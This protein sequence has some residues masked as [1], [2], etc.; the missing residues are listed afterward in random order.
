MTASVLGAR[1]QAPLARLGDVCRVFNGSTPS[2]TNARFWNGDIVWVTP[3]DLGKL[4]SNRIAD[5]ARRITREGLES[6]NTTLVPPGAVVLSSRAPIGYVAIADVPLCTNQGCKTLVP[7]DQLDSE[8]LYYTLLANIANLRQ[9]GSGATFAEISKSQVENFRIPVPPLAEQRRI[10]AQLT[11]TMAVI[12][13]ARAAAR[14]RL[15]AAEALPA[16]AVTEMF[17]RP[18][19][20][21]YTRRRVDELCELLPSKSITNRGDAVVQVI[22]T[23]CL[24]ERGFLSVGIKSARMRSGDVNA[25]TVRRGEILVARSNTPDL[26]GRAT[27]F[28]GVPAGVVASDLTIRLWCREIKDGVTPEYLSAYM[29]FLFLSG[30]WRNRARGASGS[31]KKITR[32]LLS[33]ERI[34]VPP[35]AEQARIATSLAE[36][37]RATEFLIANLREQ[38][39]AL[40]ALP[41]ALL[42]RVFNGACDGEARAEAQR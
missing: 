28:P 42:C 1:V 13:R 9:L 5:S 23:A 11:A 18:E 12:D 7:G 40:D 39:A 33:A 31:M 36:R 41:A 21:A 22:T 2:S 10:A 25:C 38:V 20:G 16:A 30:Y 24:S 8:F 14:D 4:Q 6:C 27:L 35:L 19:F 37:V 15:A 3:A 17:T 34:P 29:S 32:K 26:V